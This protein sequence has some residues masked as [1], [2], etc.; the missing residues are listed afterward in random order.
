[1]LAPTELERFATPLKIGLVADTHLGIKPRPLP[2][3]LVR[4]LRRVDLI[5]HAGDICSAAALQLFA[6][7]GPPLR[8][9]VGNNDSAALHNLLPRELRFQFGRFSAGMIHG[10][11]FGRL[12][13]RQA[14]EQAFAGRVEL[15]IFGHSHRPLCQRVDGLLLVN[16]GS[17]LQR[18]W[19]P[20]HTLGILRIGEAI[21]AEIVE[22]PY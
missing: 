20:H 10:D 4:E 7:I 14:A 11:G 9:V 16:P 3:A 21:D 1:M 15:G 5:L 19:Q 6:E 12:T 8:A 18:R 2:E 22:L 13:A 17:A